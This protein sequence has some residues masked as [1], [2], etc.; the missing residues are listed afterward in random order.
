MSHYPPWG[1]GTGGSHRGAG[2]VRGLTTPHG[3]REPVVDK[4][5]VLRQLASLPPMGIGNERRRTTP[6]AAPRTHYP[7]WGSGTRRAAA[8]AV[9][10]GVPHYPPW[11]SGTP[12]AGRWWKLPGSPHYPPWGSGTAWAARSSPNSRHSLPPMGIGNLE[13][14]MGKRPFLLRSLPPMG[15]GNCGRRRP[16]PTTPIPTH[17]PPWGSGTP[18]PRPSPRRR[19]GPHYPPWG[20]GTR[21]P[22]SPTTGSQPWLTTPHGDREP[23]PLR[24]TEDHP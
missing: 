17:Y 10:D 4:L 20:S 8:A 1:S 24:C 18:R 5:T 9:L 21:R 3:D 14:G 11:G 13:L 2:V 23:V 19:S 15:I 16:M 12:A 22:A 6:E 7:P